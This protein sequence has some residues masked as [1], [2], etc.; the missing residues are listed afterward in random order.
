MLKGIGIVFIL[1]GSAGLGFSMAADLRR[2]MQE[3]Q[4]LRQV[5]LVLRSEIR[6]MHQ[7]LPEAFLN[8]SRS[9]PAPFAEFF[10]RT[11]E[12]L[13]QRK[14]QTARQIWGLNLK[15]YLSG[16]HL[17]RQESQELLELGNMLGCLDV[18]MQLN[19]LDYYLEQLKAASG[20][21]AEAA[22]SRRRLY[23]YL[24]ILSGAALAVFII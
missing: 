13:Q 9:A 14:G 19:A 22:E 10:R 3:L 23:Q 6:Y 7:P 18:E 8:L 11:A 20:R 15:K 21:A 24:G 12:D 16:L 4:T 17:G 1:A 2:R 5:M